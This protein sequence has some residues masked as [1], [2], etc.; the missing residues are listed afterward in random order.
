M[1][2]SQYI[3]ARYVPLFFTNPDDSSNN[4][5]AGVA[6]DPLTVVTDLN[7]SYTSKIPVPASVGRP[8]ENPTY[9]ILTGTYNAQV[10]QYRQDVIGYKSETDAA[11]SELETNIA[12]VK[13]QFNIK[14]VGMK[15]VIAISDSYGVQVGGKLFTDL[16]S[17]L[18]A[19]VADFYSSA[20]GSIGF[21]HTADS[22]RFITELET[23]VTGM[24][25]EEKT[26]VTHVIVMGGANDTVETADNVRAAISAF[27][28]YVYTN[29]PNASIYIGFVGY[30]FNSAEVFN[31][32]DMI[33]VYK[34]CITNLK[35][36]YL[37]GVEHVMHNKTLASDG[38][39]PNS[40]GCA[41]IA[42]AVREALVSGSVSIGYPDYTTASIGAGDWP[43]ALRMR[44]AGDVL[45][46]S[47]NNACYVILST[48]VEI[49][50]TGEPQNAWTI[51]TMDG[52][53]GCGNGYDDTGIPYGI[54]LRNTATSNTWTKIDGFLW[55]SNQ[56]LKWSPLAYAD[57]QTFAGISFNEA[58]LPRFKI[59]AATDWN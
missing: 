2:V 57:A 5:K 31:Y 34:E 54:F 58:R 42:A 23:V 24:T 49:A 45:E 13:S 32:G 36:Y 40:E 29:L 37:S 16:R 3:G 41:R 18:G 35:T 50:C 27:C 43:R 56:Q 33:Q 46:V 1:A 20:Y 30:K 7:Q 11:L 44:L 19:D 39:H 12:D 8:S 25:D 51:A 14:P 48:P 6:Y 10:E 9:W 28:S 22:R 21:S 15:K 52:R 26:N 38:L 17:Q 47:M 4:W 53:Y 55:F 59:T